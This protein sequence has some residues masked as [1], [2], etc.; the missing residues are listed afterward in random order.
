[1]AS[2]CSCIQGPPTAANGGGGKNNAAMPKWR[3][4][5]KYKYVALINVSALWCV[6][7]A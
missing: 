3:V 2:C 7:G 1:M 6:L 5:R 4:P